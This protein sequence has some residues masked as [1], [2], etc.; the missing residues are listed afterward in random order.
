VPLIITNVRIIGYEKR[1]SF[2]QNEIS[3]NY[4]E[5]QYVLKTVVAEHT[6]RDVGTPRTGTP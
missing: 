6:K 2:F 3:L 5:T 4:T 1:R